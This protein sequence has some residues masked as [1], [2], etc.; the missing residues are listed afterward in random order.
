MKLS[1]FNSNCNIIYKVLTII[2]IINIFYNNCKGCV[3]IW[4]V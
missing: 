3:D 4:M 2:I 1:Y